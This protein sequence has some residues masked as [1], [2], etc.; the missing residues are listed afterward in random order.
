MFRRRPP[1]HQMKPI[2][3]TATDW[4][5]LGV[6]FDLQTRSG[7]RTVYPLTKMN[8]VEVVRRGVRYEL[9]KLRTT[10]R[11]VVVSQP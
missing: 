1:R 9:P 10:P 4:Y 3:M 5:K 8:E 6:P 2:V 7:L 11:S